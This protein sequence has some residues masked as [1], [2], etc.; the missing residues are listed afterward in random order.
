MKTTK[1]ITCRDCGKTILPQYAIAYEDGYICSKCFESG[2]FRCFDCGGVFPLE[3]RRS[4]NPQI[5]ERY[6]CNNCTDSYT[7]CTCCEEYFTSE[8]IWAEDDERIVCDN[9][10]TRFVQCDDC[11]SIIYEDEANHCD[12]R[13][14]CDM[15]YDHYLNEGSFIKQYSYKPEPIFLGD[16][17]DNLYLGI[18]LEVDLGENKNNVAKTLSSY[19]ELYLKQDGSLSCA[20]FEIVSHPATL[21]YH[22]NSMNW[23]EIMKICTDNHYH[24]HYT[25]TC[26]L[27]I[28]LSRKFMGKTENEQDLNIAKLILLFDKW[29]DKYIVPFSRRNFTT[30]ERWASKPDMSY[31]NSDTEQSIIN[32]MKTCK[33]YGRYQAINLQNLHTIEFRI[34]RGTLNINTFLAS[35]Q[36]VVTISKF[37][38]SMRLAD[39]YSVNWSDVFCNTEYP[40]LKS[41]LE[42]KNLI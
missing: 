39:L 32:K 2:Y 14:Y 13:T 36:F 7:W 15:C 28:H 16:S 17:T 18:E 1:L 23:T 24:S 8:N 6:V 34:F 21:D 31:D 35:L 37:A 33:N 22:T 41:F 11:R 25:E 9:C 42:L 29:W 26:G 5:D 38:K 19:D 30:L 12:G 40:E 4:V 27:H 3:F 10:S 20:G